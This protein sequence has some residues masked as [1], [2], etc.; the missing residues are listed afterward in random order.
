MSRADALTARL[1][2]AERDRSA[3]DVPVRD[4][5]SLIVVDRSGGTRVL[6][7]RR[8]AAHVFMPGLFVFPGGRVDPTDAG[9]RLA[10]GLEPSA[11][12]KLA[13]MPRPAGAAEPEALAVAALRETF[14]ETGFL[15]GC[16]ARPEA[17][18]N[19]PAFSAFRARGIGLD[20]SALTFVARAET[21][22]GRP[23]RYD[24]RFFVA[25][26][27]A[28]REE[29]PGQRERDAE[30]EAV[31]WIELES[32]RAMKLPTITLTIIDEIADR[33]ASPDGLSPVDP[34]PYYHWSGRGFVRDIL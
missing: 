27:E 18:P 28:I 34:V 14:E 31:A 7:G 29:V 26:R 1:T 10:N 25:D 30:L 5:A 17:Q 12:E 21:P 13:R 23:R 11:R 4:A 16:D 32:A 9:V 24:T 20:L 6:M 33:L 2:A 19:G 3:G 8:S 15:L 22:P